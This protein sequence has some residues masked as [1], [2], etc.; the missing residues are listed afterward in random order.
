M[1]AV[2]PAETYDGM[3]RYRGAFTLAEKSFVFI[4]IAPPPTAGGNAAHAQLEQVTANTDNPTPWEMG[5]KYYTSE[6]HQTAENI[7]ATV[8]DDL[9]Q[10][11]IHINGT[12]KSIQAIGEKFSWENN[13][14]ERLLGL[15]N[16]GN[17]TFAGTVRAKN[18]FHRLCV[19]EAGSNGVTSYYDAVSLYIYNATRFKSDAQFYGFLS[20]VS[21]V[22]TGDVLVWDAEHYPTGVQNGQVF[23][24]ARACTGDADE[25]VYINTSSSSY[26]TV[27]LP[28]AASCLGKKVTV[29]NKHHS[30]YGITVYSADTSGEQMGGSCSVDSNKQ[31]V[32]DSSHPGQGQSID[33]NCSASFL[34]ISG[35]WLM[36]EY[37][38]AYS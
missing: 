5:A 29:H 38:P 26:G 22:Q 14:G 2:V 35:G 21:D 15:D 13:N 4:K 1:N 11:G 32:L 3:T 18:F 30:G 28:S 20:E 9:G 19:A 24:G 16:K 34:A 7:D 10:V 12:N 31:P 36:L 27:Y 8:R 6:I 25:V 37:T 23:D 33:A 17:A